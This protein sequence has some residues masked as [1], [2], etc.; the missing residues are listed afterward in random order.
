MAFRIP[1]RPGISHM[2]HLPQ[3]LPTH[4]QVQRSCGNISYVFLHQASQPRQPWVLYQRHR[5]G[6]YDSQW[7]VYARKHS[8]SFAA[9]P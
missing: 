7:S 1:R 2:A 4:S 5:L 8:C 9:W 6:L 3:Q